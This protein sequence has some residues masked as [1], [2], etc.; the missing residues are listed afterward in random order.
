[1]GYLVYVIILFLLLVILSFVVSK[2]QRTELKVT[3]KN[4]KLIGVI[5]KV[6]DTKDGKV[7]IDYKTCKKLPK[8]PYK[9]NIAQVLFYAYIL[10]LNGY[11][12]S[13]CIL[14]YYSKLYKVSKEFRVNYN[15]EN[16]RYIMSVVNQ[17][18]SHSF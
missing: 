11:K 6:F 7:I 5:D 10:D 2:K 15:A 1:M 13:H 17:I 9:N 14:N 8:K 12:V 18:R 16:K 3:S 4:H